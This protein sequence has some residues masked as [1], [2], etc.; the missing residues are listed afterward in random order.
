LGRVIWIHN[1]IG[2]IRKNSMKALKLFI[3]LLINKVSLGENKS[4]S[5]LGKLLE[6][7]FLLNP[8]NFVYGDFMEVS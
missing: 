7:I 2:C 4:M 6:M 3:F 5:Y 1:I 8:I